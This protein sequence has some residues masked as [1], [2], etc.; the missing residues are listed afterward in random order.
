MNSEPLIRKN[1]ES[2]NP[3]INNNVVQANANGLGTY[4]C[5]LINLNN[6]TLYYYRAYAT[7]SNGTEYGEEKSFRTLNVPS[8]T[9]GSVTGV[10]GETAVCGG[11]VVDD[12]GEPV[13]SAGICYSTSPNPTIYD[14]I[15]PAATAGQGALTCNLVSLAQGTTYYVRA[16][17]INSVGTAY[18]TQRSFT[19]LVRKAD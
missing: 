12:G 18:G 15:L 7:N 11:I 17:A 3:T 14:N 4:S 16:Y 8:V 2:H 9:T 5:N 19:T 1:N 13:T 10:T 6:G